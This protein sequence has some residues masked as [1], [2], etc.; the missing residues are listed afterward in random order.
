[1]KTLLSFQLFSKIATYLGLTRNNGVFSGVHG[2][3]INKH[4]ND[5]ALKIQSMEDFISSIYFKN[6]KF[7]KDKPALN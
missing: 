3:I 4:L 6:S 5:K 1:M 2:Q 7:F